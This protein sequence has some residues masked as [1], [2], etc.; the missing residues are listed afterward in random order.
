MPSKIYKQMAAARP[1]LG[2]ADPRSEVARVIEESGCGVCVALDDLEGLVDALRG[3]A[4]RPDET[5]RM[6]QAGREYVT[7]IWPRSRCVTAIAE[8]FAGAVS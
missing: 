6:G 5:R 4:E 1:I 7:K 2:V 8:T 3:F